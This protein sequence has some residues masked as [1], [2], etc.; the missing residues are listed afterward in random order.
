MYFSWLC[1]YVDL[2]DPEGGWIQTIY[3]PRGIDHRSFIT[4]A[5]ILHHTEFTWSIP[6]DENRAKDG[7]RLRHEWWDLIHDECPDRH[8]VL[9]LPLDTLEGPCTVL[10]M[11]VALAK[12]IEVDVMMDDRFGCRIPQW[13]WMILENLELDGFDDSVLGPEEWKIVQERIQMM[14]DR[15]YSESGH[16]GLFPLWHPRCDQRD[17]EIWW[18]AQWWLQEVFPS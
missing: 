16:G 5:T 7:L 15:T 8:L 10:E 1:W 14:L 2:G 13:F 6:T 4:L 11:L 18:Q 9:E 12:R 17:A 3:S